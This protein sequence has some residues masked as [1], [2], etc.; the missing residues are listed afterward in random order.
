MVRITC[1]ACGNVWLHKS[2]SS[3]GQGIHCPKCGHKQGQYSRPIKP[4]EHK[5]YL[6]I[7]GTKGKGWKPVKTMKPEKVEQRTF[8]DEEADIG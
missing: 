2:Q 8:N 7:H 3:R 5:E 4:M 1:D 6:T